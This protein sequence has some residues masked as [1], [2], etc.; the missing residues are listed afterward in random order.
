MSV[1]VKGGS[2]N[3][4][5]NHNDVGSYMYVKGCHILADELGAGLYTKDYFLSENRYEILNRGSHGHS[6]P[7]VNGCRQQCGVETMADSFEKTENGVKLSFAAAYDPNACLKNLTRFLSLDQSGVCIKDCFTFSK[8][9]NSVTERI[10]TKLDAVITGENT[11]SITK[12]GAAVGTV[13]FLTKG[14][15]RIVQDEYAS[16]G[17]GL[18]TVTIIEL[19]GTTDTDTM[20]LS[21]RIQ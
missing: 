8:N 13:T 17:S 1:A 6:L 5:H 19:E 10:I 3:E 11:V 14:T 2:N 15:V 9:S 4:S 16:A 21:Y 12:D 18:Q 7:I 20:E